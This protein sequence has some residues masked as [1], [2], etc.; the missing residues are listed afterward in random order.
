MAFYMI[1]QFDRYLRLPGHEMSKQNVSK[2][3]DVRNG[4]ECTQGSLEATAWREE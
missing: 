4:D 2:E 1:P 3:Q